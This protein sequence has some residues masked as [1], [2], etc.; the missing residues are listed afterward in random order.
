MKVLVKKTIKVTMRTKTCKV[1]VVIVVYVSA[2]TIARRFSMR[3]WL[4]VWIIGCLSAILRLPAWKNI[5]EMEPLEE[6]FVAQ[7]ILRSLM[8]CWCPIG[9]RTER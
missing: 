3:S 6:F 1:V 5:G 7:S 8:L 4:L 9:M 2:E